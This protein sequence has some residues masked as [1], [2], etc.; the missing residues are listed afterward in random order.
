MIRDFDDH[1]NDNSICDDD[2][3]NDD[4]NNDSDDND[5]LILLETKLIYAFRCITWQ[6]QMCC[7]LEINM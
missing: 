1:G 2:D 3:N 5:N 4:D 6:L 7:W